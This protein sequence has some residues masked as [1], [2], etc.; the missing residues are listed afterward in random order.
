[1]WKTIMTAS[2]VLYF[3]GYYWLFGRRLD[4]D[5]VKGGGGNA[6]NS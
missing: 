5:F 2:M 4:K 6:S 3:F 1:M